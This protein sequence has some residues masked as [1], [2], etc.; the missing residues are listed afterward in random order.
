MQPLLWL[1]LTK[2]LRGECDQRHWTSRY[3]RLAVDGWGRPGIRF[4]SARSD[5]TVHLLRPAI[6]YEVEC[7]CLAKNRALGDTELLHIF[8]ALSTD[9]WNTAS[10]IWIEAP[11]WDLPSDCLV[12][13]SSDREKLHGI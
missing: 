6:T 8:V 10:W 5:I 7:G 2:R 4:R 1:N 3:I 9:H 11:G 13:L 12:F